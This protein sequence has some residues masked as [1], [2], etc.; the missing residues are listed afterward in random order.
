MKKILNKT[1]KI[2]DEIYNSSCDVII[3]DD[4]YFRKFLKS[5]GISG[6]D[7]NPNWYAETGN[8][9]DNEGRVN[10]YYIRI[11]EITFTND[12]YSTIVHELAHLTFHTLEDR[13]VKFGVDNQEPYTYLLEHY[14]GDFL[15]KSMK[16][17]KTKQKARNKCSQ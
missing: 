11:P 17:Y 2:R 7:I 15:R 6:D 3:G 16:L 9:C 8:F 12:N 14:L 4:K 5:R 1:F 13:G 10:G